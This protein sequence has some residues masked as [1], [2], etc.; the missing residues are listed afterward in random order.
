MIS[1]SDEGCVLD[2][3]DLDLD[4]E[5]GPGLQEDSDLGGLAG[6]PPT[7]P[8]SDSSTG[9]GSNKAR[10]YGAESSIPT[11][12]Q[13]TQVKNHRILGGKA[14][15]AIFLS[16]NKRYKAS[17]KQHSGVWPCSSNRGNWAFGAEH[18]SFP[19]CSL[20]FGNTQK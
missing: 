8:S 20:H 18:K 4:G 16:L 5:L 11:S 17:R 7:A 9:D 1:V 2:P 13:S 12:H 19:L 10:R 14:L 6:S 15:N 3:G